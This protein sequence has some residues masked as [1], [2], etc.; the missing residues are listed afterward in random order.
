MTKLR[1]QVHAFR[2][3]SR[4]PA[5]NHPEV[6]TVPPL[7]RIQLAASLCIEEALET[8]E[9]FGADP[10]TITAMKV[11]A[12]QAIFTIQRARCNLVKVADGL[13]DTDY[14]NE[15]ARLEFGIDG[16]PVADEIQLK[17]ME[18]FGP[19][20]SFREDGKVLKPPGWTPPDIA[21]VLWSQGCDSIPVEWVVARNKDDT[22]WNLTTAYNFR[23]KALNT[24]TDGNPMEVIA[25][26]ETDSYEKAKVMYEAIMTRERERNAV[27]RES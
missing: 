18:K 13:G 9:G 14:V 4:L 6:P 17:N 1:E 11:L 8:L 2:L 10:N 5:D 19:G 23:N 16:E 20:S 15:W 3:A 12:A 21:G 25:R 7:E 27:L 22:Q 26:F 24:D